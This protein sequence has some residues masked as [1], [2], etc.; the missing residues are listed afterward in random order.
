MGNHNIYLNATPHMD[1]ISALSEKSPI[2]N[3][4][5]VVCQNLLSDNLLCDLYQYYSKVKTKWQLSMDV[6]AGF[7]QSSQLYIKV[8]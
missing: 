1:E 8:I 4:E 7:R 6:P 2:V 5:H 3:H